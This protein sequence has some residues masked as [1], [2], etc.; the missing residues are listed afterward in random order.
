MQY[1][2]KLKS[3]QDIYQFYQRMGWA[4]FLQLDAEQLAAAMDG[5]WYVLYAYDQDRLVGTGRVVS[6][7]VINA[8]LC[9][10]GVDSEYRRQGIG[11]R[12]MELLVQRCQ[13][14]GLH[15]QFFCEEQ[16]VPFYQ[17]RGYSR[18]A[19]GMRPSCH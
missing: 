18:F 19:A 5:S 11:T 3:R 6:D 16:L 13:Q 17:Q 15:I 4:D 2:S 7:G 12:I 9:G 1:T 14:S 8:Y 10:L